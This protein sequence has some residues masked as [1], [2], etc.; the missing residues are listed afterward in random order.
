MSDIFSIDAQPRSDTGKGAS[1]RLRHAGLVPGILYGAHKDP[2]MISL[3]HSDLLQHLEN[4][5][6]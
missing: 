2:E 5:T 6:F 3:V 1:R 4:E